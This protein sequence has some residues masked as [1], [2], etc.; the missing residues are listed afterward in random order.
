VRVLYFGTYDRTSPRN[1]QVISCL[2][3]AGVTVVEHHRGVF[4]RH[5]WA[6]GPRTLA[7]LVRAEVALGRVHDADADVIVVGYPGHADLAAARRVA[8]GRPVVFNPLVSLADTLVGDRGLVSR[9]SPAAAALRT[10][11][12]RAFR[13]ADLVVADTETHAIYF[14]DAFELPSD[15]V[16]VALVGAEDALFRPGDAGPGPFHALFVGKLIPLH[17]LETIL[18]AA[19]LVPEVPFVVA[20]DGQLAS[21]LRDR[22]PNVEHVPW[23]AYESLADAYR[24]AGC[25]LGIFG[26]GP[27]AARVIPNKVFQALATARPVITADTPGARELLT[28][29]LDALLV[30]PGDAEALAQAVRRLADD[31]Q[32]AAALAAAGRATYVAHASEPVLGARWRSLLEDAVAA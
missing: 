13:S 21:L 9:R 1:T 30:P 25:A 7:R 12:R 18:A 8:A 20:G 3:G 31:G 4:G 29:E 14:R 6:P 5:N 28:H 24:T 23:I 2:R 27:K 26:A 15:R 16:Q 19:A 22:P 10:L 32:L 17:G 11:D